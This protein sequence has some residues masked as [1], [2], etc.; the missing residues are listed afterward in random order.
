MKKLLTAVLAGMLAV[1]M[2]PVSAAA[3][4][5][6]LPTEETGY[7]ANVKGKLVKSYVATSDYNS[8]GVLKK[9]KSVAYNKGKKIGYYK[10]EY[11]IRNN[12]QVSA[13]TFSKYSGTPDKSK[14]VYTYKNGKLVKKV[15][16]FYDTKKKKYV[17]SSYQTI[18]T[19]SKKIV[20]KYY[21]PKGK[22]TFKSI[23]Y[24]QKDGNI[25]KTEEY[26]GKKLLSTTKNTYNKKGYLQKSV[27]KG[28][29][30]GAR[31]TA[32]HVYTYDKHNNIKSDVLTYDGEKFS[33]TVY[34]YKKFSY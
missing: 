31:T 9:Y 5:H 23:D 11:K 16:Y 7:Y 1:T 32:K 4:T 20:T 30:P 24:L 2:I 34:K 33:K 15:F 6:Y 29:Y 3:K 28:S 26:D 27:I 25:K 19:T 12:R 10:T 21:S 22:L 8:K 14:E 17:K 18:K 13:V